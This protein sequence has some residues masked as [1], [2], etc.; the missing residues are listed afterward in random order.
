MVLV[1]L[2]CLGTSVHVHAHVHTLP[3]IPLPTWAPGHDATMPTT[4]LT[5]LVQMTSVWVCFRTLRSTL[6]QV[7]RVHYQKGWH[8]GARHMDTYVVQQRTCCSHLPLVQAIVGL[9]QH[10]L[11][12]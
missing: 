5:L 11:H 3:T 2:R 7:C 9:G 4:S 12:T 6:S 1:L 10:K 8:C